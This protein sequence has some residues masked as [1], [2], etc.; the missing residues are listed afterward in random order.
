MAFNY[1]LIGQIKKAMHKLAAPVPPEEVTGE[2]PY[3]RPEYLEPEQPAA[4]DP[5]SGMRRDVTERLLK[6]RAKDK[7]EADWKDVPITQPNPYSLMRNLREKYNLRPRQDF[8]DVPEAMKEYEETI[9]PE[10]NLDF[11]M[12]DANLIDPQDLAERYYEYQTGDAPRGTDWRNATNM[13]RDNEWYNNTFYPFKKKLQEIPQTLKEVNNAIGQKLYISGIDAATH[14]MRKNPNV[15][16]E[17]AHS[18]FK[19]YRDNIEKLRNSEGRWGYGPTA[20]AS[21][22]PLRAVMG[23]ATPSKPV[24]TNSLPTTLGQTAANSLKA[25]PYADRGYGGFYPRVDP[26]KPATKPN[27]PYSPASHMDAGAPML[28]R[29]FSRTD[30]NAAKPAAPVQQS[31]PKPVTPNLPAVSTAKPVGGGRNY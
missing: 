4:I 28:D 25:F 6:D 3:V 7:L 8:N 17:E 11:L 27:I 23:Y 14:Y 21:S 24:V 15:T 18:K 2:K 5:Q 29:R 13:M 31:A 20:W 12:R 16:Y 1:K 10:R 9:K 19:N 26:N 22:L 30:V